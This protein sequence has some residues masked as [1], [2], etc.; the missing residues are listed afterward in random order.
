MTVETS[1]ACRKCGTPL[2]TPL[3][4]RPPA[5]C[6]VGCRRAAEYERKRLQRHL[7]QLEVQRN[8]LRQQIL[9][10]GLDRV[11]RRY[12]EKQLEAVQTLIVEHEARLHML[13]S[14][15]NDDE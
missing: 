12:R 1:P 3:T 7:E 4:G 5:Y 14:E 2:S 9:E 10:G 13:L 11:Q 15:G 8:H 6:S